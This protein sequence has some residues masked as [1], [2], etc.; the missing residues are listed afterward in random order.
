MAIDVLASISLNWDEYGRLSHSLE[1]FIPTDQFQKSNILALSVP[2]ITAN[3]LGIL[4]PRYAFQL[5]EDIL[6]FLE[7]RTHNPEVIQFPLSSARI[8]LHQK[9]KT[10]VCTFDPSFLEGGTM[11]PEEVVRRLLTNYFHYVHDK[12]ID[13]LAGYLKAILLAVVRFY[14]YGLLPEV[15]KHHSLSLNRASQEIQF[16]MLYFNETIYPQWRLGPTMSPDRFTSILSEVQE[17][18]HATRAR[19]T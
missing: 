1:L 10:I 14:L 2:L 7:G 4:T 3:Q 11:E 18:Y 13:E 6:S 5:C 12:V 19:I 16:S 8:D 15:L 17:Q 9:E